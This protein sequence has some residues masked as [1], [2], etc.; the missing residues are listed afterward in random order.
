MDLAIWVV[1]VLG[2]VVLISMDGGVGILALL[3]GIF[4]VAT[5]DVGD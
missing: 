5:T 3:S 2:A 1:A 4:L